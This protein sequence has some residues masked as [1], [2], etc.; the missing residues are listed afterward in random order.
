MPNVREE[1]SLAQ[2]LRSTI[3]EEVPI[4]PL[5]VRLGL[6]ENFVGILALSCD[7]IMTHVIS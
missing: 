6:R 2:L 1:I 4:Y 3:A 7:T 5:S